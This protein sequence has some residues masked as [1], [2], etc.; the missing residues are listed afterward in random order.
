MRPEEMK[1][2]KRVGDPRGWHPNADEKNK[3]WFA[4][5]QD[6][7][8]TYGYEFPEADNQIEFMRRAGKR[9]LEVEDSSAIYAA[10]P[11][12]NPN[13]SEDAQLVAPADYG[14][15]PELATA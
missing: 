14:D 8:E 4:H 1:H 7:V 15:F 5:Y 11:E 2:W 13:F 9:F 12:L 3:S 10:L 6:Y